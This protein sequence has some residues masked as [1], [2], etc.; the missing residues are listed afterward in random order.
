MVARYNVMRGCECCIS[1]KSIHSS[2]LSWRDWYLKN[3]KIKSKILNIEGLV[4]K[5]ITYMKHIKIQSCHM[6]VICMPNHLIRQRKK[7]VHIHIQIM[8]YHTENVYCDVVPDVHVLIFL[9]NKHMINITTLDFQ[10]NL[11]SI[12]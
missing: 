6:G 4:K 7:C 8:Y 3:S 1:S 9:T 11:T 2:L 10:F 5:K 12:I